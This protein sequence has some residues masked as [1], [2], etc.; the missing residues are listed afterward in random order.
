MAIDLNNPIEL[1]ALGIG[2]KKNVGMRARQAMC[3][4]ALSGNVGYSWHQM[5][6]L[7]A[8]YVG[9]SKR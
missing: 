5:Q 3:A 9:K 4:G 8:D 6:E 2:K 7:P 1:K